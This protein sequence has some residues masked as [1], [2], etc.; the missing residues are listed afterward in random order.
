MLLSVFKLGS[1]SISCIMVLVTCPV[2]RATC[3]YLHPLHV[4]QSHA[5]RHGADLCFL[6]R[7]VGGGLARGQPQQPAEGNA[8][9]RCQNSRFMSLKGWFTYVCQLIYYC[10]EYE[11]ALE[12]FTQP[13]A[14]YLARWTQWAT[15]NRRLLVRFTPHGLHDACFYTYTELSWLQ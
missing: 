13:T 6:G 7:R 5:R 4:A 10:F 3:P 11:M 12:Q 8:R 9:V 2:P 15:S 14:K 1:F